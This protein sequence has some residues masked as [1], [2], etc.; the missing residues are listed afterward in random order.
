MC[1]QLERSRKVLKFKVKPVDL[2]ALVLTDVIKFV[3]LRI[4][5][6]NITFTFISQIIWV[7][8]SKKQQYYLQCLKPHAIQFFH[9]KM[10]NQW[11]HLRLWF[12]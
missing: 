7:Q 4:E 8:L 1:C 2:I 5:K 9:Y 12:L 11:V 10:N 3:I 6:T